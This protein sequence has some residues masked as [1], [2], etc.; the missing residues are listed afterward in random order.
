MEKRILIWF[1]FVLSF[2]VGVFGGKILRNKAY[3]YINREGQ[4]SLLSQ[5]VKLIDNYAVGSES[6]SSYFDYP[7][8]DFYFKTDDNWLII[9]E[10]RN[11]LENTCYRII[12][13]CH[14]IEWSKQS[15]LVRTFCVG[16]DIVPKGSIYVY[17]NGEKLAEVPYFEIVY[18]GEA[19]T[20]KFEEVSKETLYGLI[21]IK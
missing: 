12:E 10:K 4:E 16:E 9:D 14:E 15:L 21:D 6:V 18:E 7:L 13:N 17:K 3:N 8:I 20:E 1:V 5:N 11:N 2:A 19:L